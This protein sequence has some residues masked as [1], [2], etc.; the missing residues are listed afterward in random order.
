MLKCIRV[1]ELFI[2]KLPINRLSFHCLFKY[3]HCK[4][5]V[6]CFFVLLLLL[7]NFILSLLISGGNI[8]SVFGRA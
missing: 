5:F 2:L 7:L 8:L 3:F 1:V 6:F 4:I